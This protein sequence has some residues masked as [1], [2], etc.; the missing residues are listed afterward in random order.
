VEA[1]DFETLKMKYSTA[2]DIFES[3]LGE[4]YELAHKIAVNMPDELLEKI[5]KYA[6]EAG[7]RVKCLVTHITM[8][9]ELDEPSIYI[10]VIL[11]EEPEE[12]DELLER[13]GRFAE[14]TYS[15]EE[16]RRLEDEIGLRY[17]VETTREQEWMEE[18]DYIRVGKIY[19]R[20][21]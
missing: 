4:L 13:K 6:E 2:R 16:L 7:L 3:L 18:S 15:D 12:F 5:W 14:L 19:R 20:G 8:Y 17:M 9:P 1:E 10:G 11:E 21:G